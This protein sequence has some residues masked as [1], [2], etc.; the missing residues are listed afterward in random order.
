MVS[1]AQILLFFGFPLL[2]MTGLLLERSGGHE[3]RIG[4]GKGKWTAS[5]PYPN[6]ENELILQQNQNT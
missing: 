5:R 1:E 3:F 6:S 2:L 4:P